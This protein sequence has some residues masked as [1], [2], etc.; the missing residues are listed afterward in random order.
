MN[1]GDFTRSMHYLSDVIHTIEGASSEN[2]D[3][4]SE[5]TLS[6]LDVSVYFLKM[7]GVYIRRIL[8]LLDDDDSE[9]TFHQRLAD[10]LQEAMRGNSIT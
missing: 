9:D 5:N 10:E 8:A 4:F 3:G 2:A 1:T 7:T 6:E